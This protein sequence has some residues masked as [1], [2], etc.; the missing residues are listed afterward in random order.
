LGERGIALS[1]NYIGEG[2]GNPRG[3]Q[4]ARIASWWTVQ[5]DLQI[6]FHP[7]GTVANPRSAMGAVV[8]DA[9]VLGLRTTLKF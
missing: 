4:Q 6:I 9:V 8:R 5:P 2:L 3:G 7:G 1:V